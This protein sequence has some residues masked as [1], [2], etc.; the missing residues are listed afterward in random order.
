[1]I[2]MAVALAG[3]AGALSRY[4]LDHALGA[5]YP[6]SFPVGTLLVNVSG[7]LAAGIVA[8]LAADVIVPSAFRTIIAGG[9]LGA[10]TTFSTAMYETMRL[11]EE[12]ARR[13]ALL[14]LVLPLLASVA[15]AG[16]GWWLVAR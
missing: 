4:L 5:R 15:A 16:G 3:G 13:P 6:G 12:G 7:S 11:L 2:W 10:Y 8:G 9:F 14:N 1:M